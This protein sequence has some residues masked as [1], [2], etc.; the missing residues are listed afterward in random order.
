MEK[1]LAQ[2]DVTLIKESLYDS[3]MSD[4]EK[5]LVLNGAFQSEAGFMQE[6]YKRDCQNVSAS[7]NLI[8]VFT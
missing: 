4:V 2:R 5:S 6:E 8:I 7:L 3:G 1:I